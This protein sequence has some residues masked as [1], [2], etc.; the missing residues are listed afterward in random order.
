MEEA[1]QAHRVPR[2]CVKTREEKTVGGWL[3]GDLD[4]FGFAN[5][6][7]GFFVCLLPSVIFSRLPPT[8]CPFLS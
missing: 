4:I 3:V 7:A 1:Q 5:T 6:I 2:P 8:L